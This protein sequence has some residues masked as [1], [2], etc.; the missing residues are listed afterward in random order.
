M[1]RLFNNI[2]LELDDRI[3]SDSL[4][5]VISSK[6]G[7]EEPGTGLMT[8]ATSVE[9]MYRKTTFIDMLKKAESLHTL[10]QEDEFFIYADYESYLQ[11]AAIWLKTINRDIDN[12]VSYLFVKSALTQSNIGPRKNMY[13][14]GQER[15]N[16]R[17]RD[18][19]HIWNEAKSEKDKAFVNHARETCEVSFHIAKY[20]LDADVSKLQHS[21]VPFMK[22]ALEKCLAEVKETIAYNVLDMDMQEQLFEMNYD[23]YNMEDFWLDPSP[24][25]RTFFDPNLWKYPKMIIP[26]PI[27]G[28]VYF[29]RFTDQDIENVKTAYEITG[30]IQNE[31]IDFKC[32]MIRMLRDG[33]TYED[34]ATLMQKEKEATKFNVMDTELFIAVNSN[35]LFIRHLLNNELAND[36]SLFEKCAI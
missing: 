7:F 4:R 5:M 33:I 35:R 31:D 32:D 28:R 13:T 2:N 19:D 17:S 21:I 18:W 24:I 10:E 34:V 30:H 25:V 14:D 16:L 29:E 6:Y 22:S 20:M 3:Q 36:K 23:A 27:G 1:I 8:W 26:S 9:D 11:L 15:Y 12:K